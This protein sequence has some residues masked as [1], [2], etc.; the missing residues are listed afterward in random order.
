MNPFHI[1]MSAPVVEQIA[2]DGYAN[3]RYEVAGFFSR[4][5]INVSIRKSYD[6][7]A[8][9][10]VW[11]YDIK[12]G[13]CGKDENFTGSEEDRIRNLADALN[14]AANMV[15]HLRAKEADLEAALTKYKADMKVVYAREEAARVAAEEAKLKKLE[16]YREFILDT[17][18][19]TKIAEDGY[20]LVNTDGKAHYASY[21]FVQPSTL[22]RLND[23][24]NYS[25]RNPWER[26]ICA[27]IR[28]SWGGKTLYYFNEKRMSKKRFIDHIKGL[29]PTVIAVN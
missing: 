22:L 5:V 28:H 17:E 12:Y 14:S 20:A 6:Y 9:D 21:E 29:V 26:G 11:S 23:E 7:D 4:E 15:T 2:D 25:A 19:A 16:A 8:D 27:G 10:R 1:K 3:V 13:I 24:N 18:A